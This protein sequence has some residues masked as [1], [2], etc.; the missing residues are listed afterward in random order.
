[1]NRITE[2]PLSSMHQ[3]QILTFGIDGILGERLRELAETQRFRLRE[4]SQFGACQNLLRTAPSVFILALGRELE[5]E[6]SLL[7]QAHACMP[8]TAT[9]V[10]GEADN[11]ALVGLAWDLGATYTLFPPTPVERIT[12]IVAKLLTVL[13]P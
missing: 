9:I 11:P 7:E 5:R 10:V 2:I 6:L 3:T 4:T 1:M 12:E 13:A 8:G